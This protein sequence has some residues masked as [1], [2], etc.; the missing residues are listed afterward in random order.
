MALHGLWPSSGFSSWAEAQADWAEGLSGGHRARPQSPGNQRLPQE[1][2]QSALPERRGAEEGAGGRRWGRVPS[3]PPR[4]RLTG[5]QAGAACTRC[6]PSGRGRI[7]PAA[8]P[9]RRAAP[10]PGG[11]VG[12]GGAAVWRQQGRGA[13]T[14][15]VQPREGEWPAN[16]L[17]ETTAPRPEVKEHSEGYSSPAPTPGETSQSPRPGQAV[18]GGLGHWLGPSLGRAEGRRLLPPTAKPR[19]CEQARERGR[20][21]QVGLSPGEKREMA[22]ISTYS[23]L[24]SCSFFSM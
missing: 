5:G 3:H 18:T 21:D 16:H 15:S 19:G 13:K 1:W 9:R 14:G 8:G 4:L 17:P 2:L 20:A 12:R 7:S 6:R 24:C 22:C 23:S 11:L 10:H